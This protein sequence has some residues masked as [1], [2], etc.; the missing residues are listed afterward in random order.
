MSLDLKKLLTTAITSGEVGLDELKDLF[1]DLFDELKRNDKEMYNDLSLKIYK[2]IYGNTIT[3]DC[4]EE[5]VRK[6]KPYGEKWTYEGVQNYNKGYNQSE[7]YLVMNM[8]Y[9]DYGK[10][11]GNDNSNYVRFTE[12][13]LDDKDAKEN[14]TFDYFMK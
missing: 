2:H 10:I 7:F 4:A 9:N 3:K 11:I 6:M 14:K 8:F 5:I 1:I 13:W 12:A